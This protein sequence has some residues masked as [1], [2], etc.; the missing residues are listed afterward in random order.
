VDSVL[1]ISFQMVGLY[2]Q[3]MKSCDK[4]VCLFI[5]IRYINVICFFIRI[6]TCL[7]HVTN[8]QWVPDQM[9]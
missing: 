8:K 5:N 4:F 3:Q 1:L 2:H 7:G 9:N 6:V